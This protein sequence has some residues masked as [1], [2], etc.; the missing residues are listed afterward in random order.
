MEEIAG[1]KYV[2]ELPDKYNNI[3]RNRDGRHTFRQIIRF[4]RNLNESLILEDVI[5]HQVRLENID[6]ISKESNIPIS[7]KTTEKSEFEE[8]IE[9]MK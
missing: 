3:I 9:M 8:Y 2:K 6:E 4:K 5:E 7:Y 1:I